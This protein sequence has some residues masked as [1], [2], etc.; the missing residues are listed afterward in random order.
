M[1]EVFLKLPP[2][3]ALLDLITHIKLMTT[4]R[5]QPP[6]SPSQQ[7]PPLKSQL[8]AHLKLLLLLN[9]TILMDQEVMEAIL[10]LVIMACTMVP[11]A[12]I[13]IML[14][15]APV[16]LEVME[17]LE[18]IL[19]DMAEVMVTPMDLASTR[20]TIQRCPLE[21]LWLLLPLWLPLLQWLKKL[22]SKPFNRSKSNILFA[23]ENS[24]KIFTK[25]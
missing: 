15:G 14:L 21:L 20:C 22:L 7:L 10:L 17:A 2:S 9:S 23:L 3:D 12:F 5:P 4:I 1:G 18:D 6:P 24:S 11:A 19:M 25:K 8:K 16:L 13:T